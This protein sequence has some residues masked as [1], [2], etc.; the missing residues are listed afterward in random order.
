MSIQM[1]IKIELKEIRKKLAGIRKTIAVL[2][3]GELACHVNGTHEKWYQ[4]NFS[5]DKYDRG[6][7]IYIPKKAKEEAERLAY[8]TYL[9]RIKEDLEEEE[10]ILLEFNE[11]LSRKPEKASS[12]YASR[13]I[14]ELVDPI[15]EQRKSDSKL[16]ERED[17]VKNSEHPEGLTVPT[18]G[19]FSVRSKSEA[20]IANLLLD[21]KIPF[22]YEC[23][24]SLGRR[25]YFPDFTIRSPLDGR[26]VIWE[27]FGM[28]DV[29][30]YVS[31]YWTKMGKYISNGFIP[32]YNLI[33]TYETSGRPFDASVADRIIKMM[34]TQD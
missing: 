30:T 18:I 15:L 24:Q 12:Y 8:K 9:V 2:P 5:D 27:H 1:E 29:T 14:K 3:E 20:L 13:G 19:G 25:N 23:M 6:K 17:Y 26:I 32:Y 16:W 4:T 7:R 34:F 31:E 11:K 22:R 28:M 21:R 10:K 33:T